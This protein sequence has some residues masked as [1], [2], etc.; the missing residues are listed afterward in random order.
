M[1]S[2]RKTASVE[3]KLGVISQLETG[4]QIVDIGHNV[5]LSDSCV[6]AVHVD[7]T[8]IKRAK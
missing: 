1:K 8:R 4:K 2:Q 7:A 5:R 6:R 3:E